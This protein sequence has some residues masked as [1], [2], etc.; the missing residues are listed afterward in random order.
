MYASYLMLVTAPLG[1]GAPCRARGTPCNVR[2]LFQFGCRLSQPSAVFI[3]TRALAS[4]QRSA[5]IAAVFEGGSRAGT[6][7][8]LTGD[9]GVPRQ[10]LSAQVIKTR[11]LASRQRSA[12]IAAVFEGGSRAGTSRRLT[13]DSGVPRQELSAQVR[14]ASLRSSLCVV[15]P[16]RSGGSCGH[17]AGRIRLINGSPKCG[18]QWRIRDDHHDVLGRQEIATRYRQDN[19]QVSQLCA[20]SFD[21]HE[22]SL[23]G[24]SEGLENEETE[25][26]GSRPI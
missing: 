10:E 23:S 25:I 9:S 14:A 12:P 11:A 22:S 8:R 24:T 16:P 1:V 17:T 6:S 15:Q 5:P 13:G 19:P 20:N 7:R 18:A 26:H 2:L 4:R 3:K 21:N